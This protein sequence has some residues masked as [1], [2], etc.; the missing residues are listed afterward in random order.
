MLSFLNFLCT[1]VKK[2]IGY[3]FM[4]L[5]LDILFQGLANYLPWVKCGLLPIFV[6][7]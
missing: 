5:F 1:F 6:H 3:I 7:L 2:L 4:D